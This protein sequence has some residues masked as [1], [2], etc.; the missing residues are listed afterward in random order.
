MSSLPKCCRCKCAPP[1]SALPSTHLCAVLVCLFIGEECAQHLCG[2]QR[3]PNRGQFS[4]PA[5]GFQGPNS[6][7]SGLASTSPYPRHLDSPYPS[8]LD[9]PYPHHV[10]SPSRVSD[11]LCGLCGLWGFNS[12]SS[13]STANTASALQAG[14]FPQI[15]VCFLRDS[16]PTSQ[17]LF[18]MFSNQRDLKRERGFPKTLFFPA[19]QWEKAQRTLYHEPKV[20]FLVWVLPVADQNHSFISLKFSASSSTRK[21]NLDWENKWS[22]GAEARQVFHFFLATGTQH[23]KGA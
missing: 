19:R 10:D 7:L 3:T 14:P 18:K 4:F 16:H 11:F 17:D 20:P 13:C 23:T 6:D 21:N 12:G 2:G 9:S 5:R 1:Y 15:T 22:K 8:H